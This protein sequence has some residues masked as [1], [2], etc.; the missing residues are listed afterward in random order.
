VSGT[1]DYTIP[2][3]NPYVASATFKH[4]VWNW[5]LRNPWRFSFDRQ[6]GDLY[7]GD[8]GQDQVEEVDIA[9]SVGTGGENYGWNVVEGD[10]C[11]SG[12]CNLAD[13]TAPVLTY[14]H[15]DGCAVIGGY[16]YRGSDIPDLAGT[17]FYGDACSGFVRSFKWSGGAVTGRTAW[18]DLSVQSGLQSFG[19]DARGELYLMTA[20]GEVFRIVKR[21]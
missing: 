16:V 15:T 2:P 8:V 10:Q 19:E 4:E 18:Q 20:G 17:Y 3:T 12:P 5:G 13:F 11:Y 7:I 6:T 1:G 9:G 14:R 21:P